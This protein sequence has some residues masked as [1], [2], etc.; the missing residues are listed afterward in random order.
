MTAIF[1]RT[2]RVHANDTIKARTLIEALPYIDAK[3]G[4]GMRRSS[5]SLFDTPE[6]E[7]IRPSRL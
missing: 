1:Y 5:R 3:A 4:A 6:N 2:F 7:R